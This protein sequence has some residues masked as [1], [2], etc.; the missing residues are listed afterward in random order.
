MMPIIQ[1]CHFASVSPPLPPCTTSRCGSVGNVTVPIAC[2]PGRWRS[3]AQSLLLS[4]ATTLHPQFAVRCSAWIS[5]SLHHSTSG[6]CMMNDGSHRLRDTVCVCVLVYVFV[7]GAC[8]ERDAA[9][10]S[11][12]HQRVCRDWFDRHVSSR[13]RNMKKSDLLTYLICTI[14]SSQMWPWCNPLWLTRLKILTNSSQVFNVL[15]EITAVAGLPLS[16][17]VWGS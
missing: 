11:V 4:S 12:W 16:C 10:S 6:L 1:R 9:F 15:L 3:L 2:T 17:E 5:L 8:S 13:E 14:R 7:L